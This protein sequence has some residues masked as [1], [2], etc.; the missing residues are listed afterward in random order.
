[1]PKMDTD[2]A[3]KKIPGK[4]VPLFIGTRLKNCLRFDCPIKN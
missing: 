2:N 1:M 4:N 3:I